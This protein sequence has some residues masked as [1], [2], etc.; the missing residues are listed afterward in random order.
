MLIEVKIGKYL[1][2]DDIVR[3]EDI[4]GREKTKK[5]FSYISVFCFPG[6]IRGKDGYFYKIK[7]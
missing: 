5:A 2:E 3:L 4:Y 1:G 7:K 6:L